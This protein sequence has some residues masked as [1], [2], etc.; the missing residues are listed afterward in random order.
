MIVPGVKSPHFIGHARGIWT[1]RVV[2]SLYIHDALSLLLI[3]TNHI[4]K[5][6]ALP[7][8]KPLARRIQLVLDTPGH[9]NRCRDLGVRVRPFIPREQAL[10]LEHRHIF[11]PRI[12]LQIR[13]A[14]RPYPQ[15]APDLFTTYLPH[16]LPLLRP[17]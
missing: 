7:L 11:E 5:D 4:A 17:S 16:P 8:A 10:V 12:F 9:K 2:I 13:D 1:S 14:R 3:L 6:A 15:H